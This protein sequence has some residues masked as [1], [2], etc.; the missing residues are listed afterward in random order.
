M[1]K[2]K[3]KKPRTELDVG[4]ADRPPGEKAGGGGEVDEPATKKKER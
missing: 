1:K 2:N 3:T 4:Q